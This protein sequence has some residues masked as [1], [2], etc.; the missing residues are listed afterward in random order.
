MKMGDDGGGAPIA[1]M[2]WR[3]DGASAYVI[4]P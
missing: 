3:P 4:F 2:E 1:R